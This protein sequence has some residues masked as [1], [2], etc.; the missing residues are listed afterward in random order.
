MIEETDVDPRGLEIE[1]TESA[2]MERTE[3][4]ARRLGRFRELGVRLAID[5]IGTGHSSLANLKRMSVDVLKIDRSFVR[6][7][8]VDADII[9]LGRSLDLT[10][11]A[12]GVETAGQA[13]F[14]RRLGCRQAQGLLYSPALDAVAL[15]DWIEGRAGSGGKGSAA[16]S[17]VLGQ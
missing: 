17:R 11:V 10:V 12:E 15:V 13:D 2:L 16:A 5:D 1:I 3:T 7:I 14:L 6:D 8:E 9:Q 4:I